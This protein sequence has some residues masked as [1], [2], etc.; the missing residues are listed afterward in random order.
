MS[1]SCP[2]LASFLNL[3]SLSIKFQIFCRLLSLLL[4]DGIVLKPT[5]NIGHL[6]TLWNKSRRKRYN[7]K[8]KVM[9]WAGIIKQHREQFG[10][11]EEMW[12]SECMVNFLISRAHFS[13]C[14]LKAV[15]VY[16]ILIAPKNFPFFW[17]ALRLLWFGFYDSQSKSALWTCNSLYLTFVFASFP[18]PF[19]RHLLL[20]LLVCLSVF[21]S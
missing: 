15:Q 2:Y 12:H 10:W 6:S 21:Q 14:K 11:K 3:F 18:K 16:Q 7:I 5:I 8:L 17:S 19:V 1:F 9:L 4:A 20:G 13:I